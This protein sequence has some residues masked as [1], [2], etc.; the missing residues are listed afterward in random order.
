MRKDK[1]GKEWKGREVK[2]EWREMSREWR[3]YREAYTHREKG[4]EGKVEWNIWNG[5]K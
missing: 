1:G 5:K 3:R 2:N 4:R